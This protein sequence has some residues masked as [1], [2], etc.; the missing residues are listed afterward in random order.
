M[1]LLPR[2]DPPAFL[3]EFN[4]IPGQLDQWSRAIS[5][6]FDA[7][8]NSERP[9]VKG[10]E[11]QLYNPA[12]TDPAGPLVAQSISWNAFPKELLVAY[13]RDR[14][15]KEA[16]TMWPLS[17]YK[18]SYFG[19][20]MDNTFYRPQN[21]YCE[22]R[23]SRD[24]ETNKIVRVVFT[25]EPPEY[26]QA[27]FGGTIKGEW[28]IDWSFDFAGDRDLVLQLYHDMVSPHVQ[29][30]DLICTHDIASADGKII[31]ASR[32]QYNPYNKWNTT[33]GMVHLCAPPSSLAAEIELAA[34]ATVLRQDSLGSTLV[35]PEALICCSGYGGPNRNSDPTI[36][37]T[38]NA[39]ARMG[40]MIS[41]QN[42]VGLYMDHID[43]SGWAA[44]DGRDVIDCVRIVRGQ[45]GMIERLVVEVPA[46]RAFMVSDLE[47]AGVPIAY[48]G[49]IAECITV[50]LIGQA[51][52]VTP[53]VNNTPAQCEGRCCIKAVQPTMFS[54]W[55]SSKISDPLGTQTAL[56]DEG[57]DPGAPSHPPVTRSEII[58]N[59][60]TRRRA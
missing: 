45:P 31:L 7:F 46:G 24:P 4:G 41:L 30:D 35:E 55:L 60:P 57:G 23:V 43:L 32:G 36:G 59:K 16:D 8:I 56:V 1:A 22:W 40:A 48:G 33:E 14:A 18:P 11:V 58:S 21:E 10:G 37:A 9:Y 3:S 2:F 12:K 17:R 13:G 51:V 5:G 53:A 34:D 25:S 28:G 44:P 47:I 27:M 15:L 39:L 29:V 6:W 20:V 49:Q 54:Q 19:P 52:L 50:K 26:W 38:V 42:P